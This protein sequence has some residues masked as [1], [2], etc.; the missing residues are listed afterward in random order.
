LRLLAAVAGGSLKD[1][2]PIVER[3]PWAGAYIGAFGAWTQGRGTLDPNQRLQD[4]FSDYGQNGDLYNPIVSPRPDNDFP[5]K[6][7]FQANSWGGGLLFGRSW[8]QGNFVLGFEA[9]VSGT[10]VT[11]TYDKSSTTNA[12]YLGNVL[13][14]LDD[15][16][17][18]TRKEHYTSSVSQ[19]VD[20][21]ARV[22]AGVVLAPNL[23][24]YVTAGYAG[25]YLHT[26]ANYL[27][28]TDYS[29]GLGHP[30]QH[31]S[32]GN[33]AWNDWRSGIA[34]GTGFEAHIGRGYTLGLDYRFSYFGTFRHD[35][36]VTRTSSSPTLP[37][38]GTNASAI[39]DPRIVNVD[40]QY[41]SQ[42]LSIRLKKY[43]D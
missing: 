13:T 22:R 28:I 21:T 19:D 18:A 9:D 39:S 29:G 38:G 32:S 2:A 4:R 5:F 1:D 34:L 37:N 16:L 11:N 42:A 43:F 15:T 3:D 14:P 36:A 26:K 27:A 40:Q 41:S 33:G 20:A 25:T 12:V 24:G 17:A 23:L 7:S 31:V 10:R 35:L 8:R 6:Q 30:I